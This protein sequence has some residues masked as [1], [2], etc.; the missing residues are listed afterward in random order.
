MTAK[1]P[2]SFQFYP[3]DFL[4][5]DNVDVM[6]NEELG[7]YIRLMCHA[8]I[9]ENRLTADEEKLRK[10][11]RAV[12]CDWQKI[13]HAVL[14]CFDYSD[15][16]LSHKRLA[17]EREKQRLYS[18]QKSKSGKAGA[19]ARWDKPLQDAGDDGKGMAEACECHSGANATAM[20]ND[21]SS[22]SSSSSSS[23]KKE[24][25][26]RTPPNPDIKTF[27]D[28]WVIEYKSNR[29][30]DYVISGGK[31]GRLLK[32]LLAK[33][34]LD[35]VK[36]AAGR[37]LN[38]EWCRDSADIGLLV[39][40]YNKFTAEPKV[41]DDEPEHK[42]PKPRNLSEEELRIVLPVPGDDE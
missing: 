24:S 23:I 21:S 20:A 3:K 37:M 9:A 5:D 19:K 30:Q 26:R 16:V 27:L 4:A 31:E 25:R 14:S 32:G 8:W 34:T 22:S 41:T 36:A 15:N 18:K 6:T 2:P 17:E 28:W 42:Y 11:A 12:P 33:V 38:A 40:N 7:A 13:C 29:G 1:K 39:S 10:L 35:E